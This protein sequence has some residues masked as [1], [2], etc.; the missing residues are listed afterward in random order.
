MYNYIGEI[1]G[2][3]KIYNLTD[4]QV[5]EIINT[6]EESDKVYYNVSE[7]PMLEKHPSY[8]RSFDD[9]GD[10]IEGWYWE[11]DYLCYAGKRGY[12]EKV[13]DKIR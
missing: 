4:W 2:S 12:E 13:F 11:G 5:L 3:E 10:I 1:F 9:N 7:L 6:L 8:G